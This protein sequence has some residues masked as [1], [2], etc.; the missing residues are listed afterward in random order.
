MR[1]FITDEKVDWADKE[2]S[3]QFEDA[4]PEEPIEIIDE[5]IELIDTPASYETHA[6]KYVVVTQEE[7]GLEFLDLPPYPEVT[8]TFVDNQL[9]IRNLE[10]IEGGQTLELGFKDASGDPSFPSLFVD[11]SGVCTCDTTPV[12]G[13]SMTD[14]EI[15]EAYERNVD[16][17]ALTDFY[18]NLLESI[19]AGATAD[20]TGSQIETLL[21]IQL[22]SASWKGGNQTGAEIEALLDTELGNTDWKTGSSGG[23]GITLITKTASYSIT[24]T[25]LGG[26]YYHETGDA[27]AIVVTVPPSLTGT[28]PLD[29]ERTGAGTVTFAAGAG[30]TINS[31]DGFL[32]IGTQYAAATLVPKGSDVY[33]LIGDLA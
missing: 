5:F 11:L 29:V 18:V 16:S 27:S 3:C 28:E 6:G 13:A 9:Y 32:A 26:G 15:K 30:V 1:R 10:L 23:T 20:Q 33:T 17:N 25:D 19:E 24:D 8:D 12:E 22:G 7:D 14:L 21:D 2:S 4:T 31:R